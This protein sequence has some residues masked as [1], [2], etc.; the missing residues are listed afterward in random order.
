M[1][2]NGIHYQLKQQ[3]SLLW[4]AVTCVNAGSHMFH[5]DV[6]AWMTNKDGISILQ[7][8]MDEHSDRAYLSHLQMKR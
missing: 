5:S 6:A 1:G 7:G 2:S 8:C 4:H 3:R